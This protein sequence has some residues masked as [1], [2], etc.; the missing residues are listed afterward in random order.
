M[1]RPDRT[2]RRRW[3]AWGCLVAGLA[4]GARLEGIDKRIFVI[5]GDGES[6]D[7]QVWEAMDF[8]VD[9]EL[10]NVCAIFSC[11]G[12]GQAACVSPQ[13]SADAIA[14]KAA[15]FGWAV[16]QV[17]GHEPAEIASALDRFTGEGKPLA[18]VARTVKGW[19]VEMMLGKN[20]HG[21][22]VPAGDLQKACGQLDATATRLGAVPGTPLP[23]P[24]VSASVATASDVA[25]TAMPG[26]AQR[27]D[28]AGRRSLVALLR[29]FAG[30]AIQPTTDEQMP[31]IRVSPDRLLRAAQDTSSWLMYG[32]D[33]GQTRYSSLADID[34]LL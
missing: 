3:A 5:V 26:F 10:A 18:I 7:G 9:H 34:V 12:H 23:P 11:N 19:G 15:A 21:K 8:I 27:I 20:F 16:V 13:Q 25:E 24:S 33:Y 30:K 28:T 6:R 14:N 2:A 1:T 22:P 4:L 32:L 29:S 17:D 31:D